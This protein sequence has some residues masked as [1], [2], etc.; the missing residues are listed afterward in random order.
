MIENWDV[1]LGYSRPSKQKQPLLPWPSSMVWLGC[2]YSLFNHKFNHLN[3]V[4][5]Q[6]H[7]KEKRQSHHE[8]THLVDFPTQIWKQQSRKNHEATYPTK[9]NGQTCS[10]DFPWKFDFF[11]WILVPGYFRTFDILFPFY[12]FHIVIHIFPFYSFHIVIHIW[13]TIWKL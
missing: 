3:M 6:L 2:G 9:A 5:P 10:E 12:S 13:M 4:G 7:G 1:D 11:L 8:S